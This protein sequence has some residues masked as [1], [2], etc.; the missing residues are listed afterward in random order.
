V[1]S[2]NGN[3]DI[4]SSWFAISA[5]GT[6]VRGCLLVSV[7]QLLAKRM[8]VTVQGRKLSSEKNPLVD[9]TKSRQIKSVIAFQILVAAT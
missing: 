2:A 9:Q 4:P 8:S 5:C 1:Y 6:D 3:G 7:E